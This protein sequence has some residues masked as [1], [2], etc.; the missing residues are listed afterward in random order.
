MP[1]RSP[2]VYANVLLSN[3]VV[4][5]P[6]DNFLT[7]F[8]ARQIQHCKFKTRTPLVPPS[9]LSR[10]N[11]RKYPE[12]SQASLSSLDKVTLGCSRKELKKE[13]NSLESNSRIDRPFSDC[14]NK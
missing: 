10:G 2:F 7:L 14:E 3:Y 6:D 8:S 9:V 5:D 11:G 12:K 13:T 1:L 4:F